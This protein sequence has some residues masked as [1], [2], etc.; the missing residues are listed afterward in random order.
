MDQVVCATA[1]VAL[2]G[3]LSP[4]QRV[5]AYRI[6]DLREGDQVFCGERGAERPRR[7][8]SHGTRDWFGEDFSAP[9]ELLREDKIHP[10]ANRSHPRGASRRT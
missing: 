7:A 3:L 6:Q 9:L 5:F 4:R 2:W 10:V 8:G 1:T